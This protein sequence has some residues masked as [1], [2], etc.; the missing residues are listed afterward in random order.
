MFCQFRFHC[1]TLYHCPRYKAWKIFILHSFCATA[2]EQ[3]TIFFYFILPFEW[4]FKFGFII[5]LL[6]YAVCTSY[7]LNSHNELSLHPDTRP[8]S[9]SSPL[10]TVFLLTEFPPGHHRKFQRH[11]LNHQYRINTAVANSTY[12]P[13]GCFQYRHSDNQQDAHQSSYPRK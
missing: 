2:Q 5:E 8:M 4:A 13:T 10:R 3:L 11:L 7:R 6:S 12:N 9:I 1:L